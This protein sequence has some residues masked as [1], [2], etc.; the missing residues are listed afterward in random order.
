MRYQ[1]ITASLAAVLLV[2]GGVVLAI[3]LPQALGN[4]HRDV[5]QGFNVTS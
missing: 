2:V 4:A 1:T 3:E 5:K